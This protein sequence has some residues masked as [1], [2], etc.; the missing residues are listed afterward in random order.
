MWLLGVG[1]ADEFAPYS[2]L[3]RLRVLAIQSEPPNPRPNEPTQI[4]A[5]VFAPDGNTVMRQWSWCP[6]LAPAND[7]YRCPLDETMT[8]N[9]LGQTVTSLELG[10]E[11]SAV[12]VSP[13]S[14]ETASLLCTVGVGTAG[15]TG[16]PDCDDGFPLTMV[17]DVTAGTQSLRAG[18]TVYL[19][20][21]SNPEPNMNPKIAEF[22]LGGLPLMPGE[23][24]ALTVL[25]GT[26][27]AA[28]VSLPEDVAEFRPIPPSEAG[29]GSRLERLTLSW[30][31]SAG[32]MEK[33]RTVFID[34][35]SSPGE[36]TRNTW[37]APE[38]KVWPPGPVFFHVVIRDDRGGVGWISHRVQLESQP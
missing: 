7:R 12:F 34:G 13:L 3:D 24:T 32:R 8:S 38:T 21:N 35:V 14:Q 10:A 22:S 16:A 31:A 6:V 11:E 23:I 36:S 28:S 33:D 15:Y 37:T 29:S 19:P 5:L 2:Q 30:F 17:L 9:V 20:T 1:C 25:P 27:L 4:S 26:P 18:F